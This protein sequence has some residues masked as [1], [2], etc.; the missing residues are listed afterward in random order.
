MDRYRFRSLLSGVSLLVSVMLVSTAVYTNAAEEDIVTRR[1]L[2]ECQK[3][4]AEYTYNLDRAGDKEFFD[5][6]VSDCMTARK[7]SPASTTMLKSGLSAG[8]MPLCTDDDMAWCSSC[9]MTP[10]NDWCCK[11][12]SKGQIN[13]GCGSSSVNST[14]NYTLCSNGCDGAC[15]KPDKNHY[16]ATDIKITN[17]TDADVTFMFVTGAVTKPGEK[18]ACTDP[19]KIISYQW[20]VKNTDWCTSP[21][22][23]E[24]KN[25]GWCKGLVKKGASVELK[26][27]GDDAK[28]CLTGAIHLWPEKASCPSPNGFTQG[29]F[30]LNPTDT[31]TEAVNISLVNG[32]SYA[33]SINLPGNAWTIQPEVDKPAQVVKVIGPNEALSG[34]N[35]K[36]GIYPPGCTDCIQLVGSLPC[37][38]VP[39][40]KC[41]ATRQCHVQRGGMTGGTVEFVIEKKLWEVP[42]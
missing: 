32:A 6:H 41:Q 29:E 35:N 34:D 31:D 4:A 1:N 40:A 3:K 18:G 5:K 39:N 9:W 16:G 42:K 19:D 26:R 25:A 7:G 37:K 27:T 14:C 22:A 30:T 20:I 12:K 33:M 10:G 36:I 28:K 2:Y 24:V 21:Q 15:R 8:S 13:P 17:Q 11:K 23:G 38:N